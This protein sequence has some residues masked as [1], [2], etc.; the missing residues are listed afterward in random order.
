MVCVQM[1]MGVIMLGLAATRL[2]AKEQSDTERFEDECCLAL[3][4]AEVMSEVRF[5]DRLLDTVSSTNNVVMRVDA[6]LVLALSEYR[7]FRDSM[8]VSHLQAWHAWST[9]A[10]EAA[11]AAPGVESWQYTCACF[12]DA[13]YY[14]SKNDFKTSYWKLTNAIDVVSRVALY[15]EPNRLEIAVS[16]FYRMD[17][18]QALT[19]VKILAGASA[20]KLGYSV[21]ATNLA[22]QVPEPHRTRVMELLKTSGTDPRTPC[23]H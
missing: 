8:D 17:G 18:A 12:L 4:N 6:M 9:N 19:A 22:E 7:Q 3:R 1:V 21:V 15:N 2:E 5:K 23:K 20:A 16:D 11:F 10:L 13:A 14:A